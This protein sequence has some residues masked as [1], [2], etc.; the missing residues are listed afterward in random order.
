MHASRATVAAVVVAISAL[1][2]TGCGSRDGAPDPA[3]GVSAPAPA[4]T[5]AEPADAS[6]PGATVGPILQG[7]QLWVAA[8]N[9]QGGLGGHPVKHLTYDDGGDPA[10]HRAQ[11]QEAVETQRAIAFLANGE[12]VSGQAS[13]GYINDKKIPV[14]GGT[15]GEAW[16]FTSPMYF[17]QLSTGDALWQSVIRGLAG[18]LVPAGKLKLGTLICVEAPACD[19]SDSTFSSEAPK[20]GLSHVYKGRASLAQPDYTAECL[21]ARNAGADAILP[22]LDQTSAVRAAASCARQGYR[23]IWALAGQGVSD[24]FKDDPNLVGTLA[25]SGT[26]PYFQTGTP[27]TDEFQAALRRFGSK[28]TN[29]V[30][31]SVGWTAGKL[32]EKAAARMAE[33]PTSAALLEGLWSIAGDDLGGL[34]GRLTFTRNEPPKPF[35]CWFNLA[36]VDRRWTSPDQ[37]RVHCS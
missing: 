22:I 30:G 14:V 20:L 33:P 19:Q 5:A 21:A 31:L 37:G 9:Q 4:G 3:D 11:V 13:V 29:G 27:A 2:L 23:P 15:G 34:T 10:R 36:I 8:I 17:P 18:Q 7:A 12:V 26:F 32:L 16:A 1:G 25:S 35:V 24:Y 28:L 6:S